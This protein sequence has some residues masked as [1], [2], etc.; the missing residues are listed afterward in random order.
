[1]PGGAGHR[2]SAYLRSALRQAAHRLFCAS[3]I[4]R[5]ATADN[6]RAV[7]GLPALP[8]IPLRAE[9]AFSTCLS[10]H[11]NFFRAVI[12]SVNA[13]PSVIVEPPKGRDYS[14]CLKLPF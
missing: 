4:L 1:V 11:S 9:I 5:R 14:S 12:K 3:A 10:C 8:R 2:A 13:L 7:F 6:L